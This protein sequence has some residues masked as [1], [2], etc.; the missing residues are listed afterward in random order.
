MRSLKY[1]SLKLSILFSF[2]ILN[3]ACLQSQKM[4]STKL[5]SKILKSKIPQN[6]TFM[7]ALVNPGDQYVKYTE[8]H[9]IQNVKVLDEG[10]IIGKDYDIDY[11]KLT[12]NIERLYP[13]S[14]DKGVCFIDIEAPY[15]VPLRKS[16]VKSQEFQ[17]AKNLYVNSIK[18]CK[19]M[20]PNVLWGHYGFPMTS[21]DDDEVFEGNKKIDEI[22]AAVDVLFP[23]LYLFKDD[24]AINYQ[25]NFDYLQKNVE[26][27]IIIGKKFNKPVYPF[28]M[29]RFHNS[30][31][32][33]QFMEMDDKYWELYIKS[34]LS[35]DV[36]GKHADG[37]VWWGAD[38]FFYENGEGDNLRKEFRGTS[39]E[40]VK[41]NDKKLV[42]KAIILNE[43]LN[44]K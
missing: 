23:S 26:N 14:T 16:D 13:N 29:H 8:D 4:E 6:R 35:V 33:L 31:A 24:E 25:K 39:N 44:K 27:S 11:K 10:M 7:T 28:I 43:I 22:F 37:V 18:Y 30:D 41:F 38:T 3:G 36:Q 34:V 5:K 19:K 42:K 15:I 1:F 21:F 2:L 40:F 17:K 20:R 12:A 32:R 9:N